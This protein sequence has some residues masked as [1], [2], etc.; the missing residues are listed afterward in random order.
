[1][2]DRRSIAER[3]NW[4]CHYCGYTVYRWAYHIDHVV[5]KFA[6]GGDEESNLVLSCVMCNVAKGIMSYDE[7]TDLFRRHGRAWRDREYRL[8]KWAFDNKGKRPK[9]VRGKSDPNIGH[10][11]KTRARMKKVDEERRADTGHP[12]P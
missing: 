8:Q 5:P 11:Y 6:G 12:L 3:D 1:M 7:F 2:I 4:K 9:K 10:W